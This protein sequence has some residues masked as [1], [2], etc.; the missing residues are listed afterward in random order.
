MRSTLQ[1]ESPALSLLVT[2]VL[3][4]SLSSP[5]AQGK[6]LRM[7]LIAKLANTETEGAAVE[8]GHLAASAGDT[9]TPQR[10]PPPGSKSAARMCVHAV[11][12]RQAGGGHHDRGGASP[13]PFV[14]C[15]YSPGHP[16][17]AR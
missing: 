7:A 11:R 1:M 12:C 16:C 2:K 15:G 14:G 17:R 6:A 8:Q 13:H 4:R 9:L 5:T 10:K 3:G